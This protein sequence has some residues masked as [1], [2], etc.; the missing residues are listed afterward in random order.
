M[1]EADKQKAVL[2]SVCGGA[3]YK[4]IKNLL[5]PVKP[6]DASFKD[7]VKLL[8]EHYQP[9]P[10][11]V[12]QR[13][14]FNSRVRKQGES[15]AIYVA[16]L[17][18][19]SE[20][21]EFAATLNDM[22][23]DR[24]VCGINDS[25]I[26]CRLLAEP[27]LDYKKAYELALALE[28]T[29][30]SA[31][32]LQAKPSNIHLAQGGSNTPNKDKL[33]KPVVC[34][35]CGGPHK[36]PDCTFKKSKCHKCGKVG[37]IAKVCRSKARPQKSTVPRPQHTLQLD[38]HSSDSEPECPEY[39]MHTLSATHADPILA[40]IELNKSK[41]Q[42]EIDTGASRSIVGENTFK[43]L[44]SEDH[45]PAITPTKVKLR[46]Y[47]GELIYVLGVATV[48]VSHH[49]QSKELELLVDTG[50]GPSLIG[51]TIH[52]VQAESKLQS[53]LQQYS[54]VFSEGAGKLEGVEAKIVVDSA[55]PPKFCRARTVP[56][57]LK[58]KVEVELKLLQQTG[59]I[60]P[61]ERSDWAAPIVPVVKKDGSVR[62]CGDYRLTVNRAAK[63]DTYPLPRVDDIFASL[64]GGKTFSKLDLAN[65]YQQIPLE[66]QSKQLVTINTHKGLYC[67]NRLPF[68]ISAAPLIF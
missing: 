40:T 54:I 16:E 48:T 7:I 19:L 21:C 43:Q 12:V 61:I 15:V 68:G 52:S 8:T 18:R 17:K 30:K 11:R 5:A 13:Y 53:L 38:E 55:V 49:N 67:Y 63:P 45:R 24:L 36:A 20:H 34:H 27:D 44:W 64:S 59:I 46:T 56:H 2:F 62:I 23:C 3:T 66:Q 39:L 37:H 47:T 4:L 35:R 6:A 22:L 60:E 29:D 10:S 1:K 51:H 26:L 9:K 14:L 28:A 41:L 32:D 50:T 25:R 31:Q 58:P 65:A 33:S 57:A 42:M